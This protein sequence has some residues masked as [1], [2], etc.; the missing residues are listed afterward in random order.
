MV[1]LTPLYF[2]V[3]S[4]TLLYFYFCCHLKL[5]TPFYNCDAKLPSPI[6]L[7]GME[8][9]IKWLLSE[10]R[11]RSGQGNEKNVVRGIKPC[12]LGLCL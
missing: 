2:R 1:L 6:S 3:S 8:G 12:N 7:G 10:I 9:T 4:L 5:E 11:E